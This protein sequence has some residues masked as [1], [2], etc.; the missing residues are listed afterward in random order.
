M[1]SSAVWS[2]KK[3]THMQIETQ[4]GINGHL[5]INLFKKKF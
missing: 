3:K 2:K 1:Y 4:R 5:F